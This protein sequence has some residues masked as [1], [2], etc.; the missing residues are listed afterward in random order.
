MTIDQLNP[1]YGLSTC[2]PSGPVNHIG[3]KKLDHQQVVNKVTRI[4]KVNRAQPHTSSDPGVK[5]REMK[6]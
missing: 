5:K 3:A 6:V 4:E 2:L 1:K